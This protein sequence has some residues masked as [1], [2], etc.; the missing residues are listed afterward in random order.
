[1]IEHAAGKVDVAA[2]IVLL[3][4]GATFQ[5]H[6]VDRPGVG[7]GQQFVVA[8][9][10]HCGQAEVHQLGFAVGCHHDVRQF[11]IPM[12]DPHLPRIVQAAGDV[13]HQVDGGG[14]V[15]LFANLE[16][17]P[18]RLAFD[19]F[20][21]HVRCPHIVTD[22][23]DA[24]D[25]RMDQ[26]LPHVGFAEKQCN[27]FRLVAV[28]PPQHLDS[29]YAIG[30]RVD[31]AEDARECAGPDHVQHPVIAVEKAFAVVLDH[32]VQLKV[33]QQR[34]VQQ[35]AG[36]DLQIDVPSADL[37]PHAFQLTLIQQAKI[38]DSLRQVLGIPHLHDRHLSK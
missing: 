28:P 11:H 35:P 19:K 17:F 4:V 22:V 15:D 25:V 24:H 1:V 37:A 18:R 5:G 27:L 29:H 3:D 26:F 13:D 33:G 10:R 8:G 21:H 9:L 30:L 32:L 2:M 14:D 23:V 12:R 36:E 38:K 20:H 31:G 6:V 16:E 7:R 34:F